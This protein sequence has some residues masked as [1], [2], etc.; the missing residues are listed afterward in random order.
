MKM[1][2]HGL[3]PYTIAALTPL[4]VGSARLIHGV[5]LPFAR[6]EF[7]MPYIPGSSVKG[8]LRAYFERGD[9]L[10]KSEVKEV[11]GS[12][13]EVVPTQAGA[14]AF[15]DA[16]LAAIP[17]RL[18]FGVWGWVTSP[19]LLE[20][21]Y[22]LQLSGGL[23]VCTGDTELAGGKARLLSDRS[24]MNF[25]YEGKVV[26]NEDFIFD[27][28]KFNGGTG[29]SGAGCVEE[30]LYGSLRKM[31][32]SFTGSSDA[33]LSKP[34]ILVSDGVVREIVERSMLVVDRVGLSSAKTVER[35]PWSEEYVPQ[36]TVF[37]GYF[38]E[39]PRIRDRSAVEKFLRS[40]GEMVFVL[41]G[42]ETVGKGVVR[43]ALEGEERGENGEA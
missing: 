26:V 39:T 11:F 10:D 17:A 3:H 28:E 25:M 13:P 18:L 43:I 36:F 14:L 40:V 42:K 9:A 19:S 29:G 6:D 2:R 20:A 27:L 16:R 8:A 23:R 1:G 12:A 4:H 24:L 41:G 15:T 35:G 30:V 38:V 34:L 32:S 5:D 37:R 33:W 7:G 21:A 31:F 22:L